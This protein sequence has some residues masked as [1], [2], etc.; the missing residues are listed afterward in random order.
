LPSTAGFCVVGW[1]AGTEVVGAMGS[2]VT[3]AGELGVLGVPPHAPRTAARNR[4][5]VSFILIVL[6]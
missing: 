3:A 2:G 6:S 4:P 5:L 1:V